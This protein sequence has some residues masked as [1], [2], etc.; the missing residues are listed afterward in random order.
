MVEVSAIRS[1]E[2][3]MFTRVHKAYLGGLESI[4]AKPID[5]IV[6][7]RKESLFVLS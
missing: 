4:E 2:A 1:N 3:I 6:G 5:P 7:F